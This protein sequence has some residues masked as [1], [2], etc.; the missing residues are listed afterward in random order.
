[1]N[2]ES[3]AQSLHALVATL[4]LEAERLLAARFGISHSQLGFLAPLLATKTLDVT[5]LA[6]AMRVSVPAVSKRTGW[7]VDRGLVV[8]DTTS[9]NGRRVLLSLTPKGR[10][11]AA[12]AMAALD[13]GLSALLAGFPDSR[14]AEFLTLTLELL[15]HVRSASA[16][17]S[18][19]ERTD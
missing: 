3:L 17:V 6:A 11:L 9:A 10:E 1:M 18:S 4:E 5:S 2:D 7:F 16:A 15:D 8:A 14:R 12:A 13:E 19:E